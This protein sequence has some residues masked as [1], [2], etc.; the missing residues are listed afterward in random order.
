VLW[1]T[2]N[3]G[4]GFSFYLF[5]EWV[6]AECS[7]GHEY[8]KDDRHYVRWGYDD[9]Q[10]IWHRTWWLKIDW[11]WTKHLHTEGYLGWKVNYPFEDLQY[12]MIALRFVPI[13]YSKG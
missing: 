6:F 8:R 12:S 7:V 10:S 9:S 3:C 11:Y 2:R 13:K 5:G 1:L 4:Y